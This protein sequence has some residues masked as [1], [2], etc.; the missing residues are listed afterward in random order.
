VT[1][2]RD[3][4]SAE[5]DARIRHLVWMGRK[6]SAYLV[7]RLLA[8]RDAWARRAFAAVAEQRKGAPAKGWL[9]PD[10]DRPT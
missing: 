6:V 1:D 2:D 3:Y 9:P 7:G 8:D 5:E 10:E 4:L